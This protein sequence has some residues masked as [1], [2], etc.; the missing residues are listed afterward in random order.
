MSS[1][2]ISVRLD[3]FLPLELNLTRQLGL[4][5]VKVNLHVQATAPPEYCPFCY[6][7]LALKS[8][9]QPCC[10]TVQQRFYAISLLYLGANRYALLGKAASVLF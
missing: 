8:H 3:K 6:L 7:R 1:S 4:C 2:S 9:K 10:R 5:A